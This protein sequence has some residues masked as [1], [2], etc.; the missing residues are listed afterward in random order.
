[1]KGFSWVHARLNES[2]GFLN[3]LHEYS[4]RQRRQVIEGV[5]SNNSIIIIRFQV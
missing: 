2:E 4:K 5:W 3:V 1:M